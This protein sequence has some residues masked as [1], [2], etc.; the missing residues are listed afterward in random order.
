MSAQAVK[1]Q[2]LRD[3]KL[4]REEVGTTKQASVLEIKRPGSYV[5]R[6]VSA[7]GRTGAPVVALP[8]VENRFELKPELEV[9][10]AEP[11]LVGGAAGESNAYRADAGE[12]FGISL[13]WKPYLRIPKY[14]VV[15]ASDPGLQKVLMKK[16][17]EGTELSF[18]KN[19]IFTGTVHYR[20]QTPLDGGWLAVSKPSRFS[21]SFLPPNPVIPI[22]KSEFTVAELAASE[23]SVLMTWTKTA[24]TQNY[25]LQVAQA[26]EFNAIIFK[27][28]LKENFFILKGIK[29][30]TYY[31]RVRS[32]SKDVSSL[33]CRGHLF[34]VRP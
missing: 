14:T 20:V 2:V 24:F 3:G 12:S 27:R 11:P 29:P 21:F 17:V 10:E 28:T 4:L 31:W 13:R 25:E 26:P 15:I 18:N 32:I 23:G 6:V 16:E 30:G 5:W 19:K 9:I 34:V 8:K 33:Y 22:D 7:V 1:F